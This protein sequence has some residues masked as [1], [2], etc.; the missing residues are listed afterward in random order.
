MKLQIEFEP[1]LFLCKQ[2]LTIAMIIMKAKQTPT[3]IIIFFH[4]TIKEKWYAK[5]DSNINIKVD[6][7]FLGHLSHNHIREMKGAV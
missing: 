1:T 5:G 3:A 4:N 2:Y 6:F 7:I